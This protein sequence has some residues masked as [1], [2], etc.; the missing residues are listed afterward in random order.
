M[1][2]GQVNI[3]TAN[4]SN[5]R[6][7]SNLLEYQLSA[8]TVNSTNF[9]KLASLPVDGQVYA[10]PLYVS[11]L[12]F[13]GV[14]RNVL[15]VATMHN[16]IFAFDA[17]STE[18]LWQ[19]TL[20]PSVPSAMLFG[21][22]GDIGG[23]V[24]I[25]S[26]PVIDLQRSIIYAVT[27]N[28]RGGLPSFS[29]HAL[30]LATGSEQL[31][32]PTIIQAAVPGSGAGGSAD[33]NVHLDPQQHIQRPGLLLANGTVY[34][35][36][37]SHGDQPPYHGW[38][39]SYDAG[40]LT[41][42]L[43]IYMST[44]NGEGGAFWQSG[45]GPAVD[46][47]GNIYAAS[48]NG[49][50]DNVQNF[51]QSFLKLSGASP[52]L[53]GSFTPSGWKAMSDADAD[54]AAGPALIS[55]THRVIGADKDGNF[56]YLDGDAMSQPGS[57]DGN[58]FQVF[59]ISAGSI[60]NF[61]VW[62]RGTVASIYVQGQGE[63]LKCFQITPTGFNAL[64]LSTTSTSVQY[65]RIGM[66]LS[67]NGAADGSGI[68]WEIT[69]NYNDTT[70]SGT[71]HAYDASNLSSELWNSEMNPADKMG[72]L[73]KF[74][75]PT[76]ANGKVYVPTLSNGVVI[77]GML[78]SAPDPQATAPFISAVASSAS[79]ATD[80]VSPGQLVAIFGSSLGPST[81]SSLQLDASGNVTNS[82]GGTQVLF[83]GTPAALIWTSANQVNA[84]VPFGISAQ[85]TQIQVQYQGQASDS[86]AVAVAPS[87][88]GI[89]SLDGSG[90]G[91][92]AIL[93]QDGSINS[94]AQ[95][96]AA[97]SSV[98]LF[99]TGAGQLSPAGVDGSVV[100]AS[101]LPVPTLPV[102]VQIGGV[103]ASVLYSGGAPG[104]VEG[105]LQVNVV[106][107]AGIASGPAVP[108]VLRVGSR[109]SQQGITISVQ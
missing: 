95:P 76:V 18:L 10:Q 94:A 86:V 100:T 91:P 48:G 77:Y 6:T 29:I 61:A 73:V 50:Y 72:P 8:S 70:T 20:G 67:A 104:L 32:G 42:Q 102:S 34:V 35:G 22:Y 37:G 13:G 66:T 27:D 30:D 68:L 16:S 19:T 82:I 62:S 1:L 9:G 7:N 56:Y 11:S 45:R 26:T 41:H 15:F 79:Y 49:D 63:P 88:P 40:D 78:P 64:P 107:P 38:L 75:G 53:I 71:L 89:F 84:V 25:L 69:G 59:T 97:G 44:P 28:L 90:A 54:L 87:T 36:F 23:E 55:G 39:V 80:A 31:G 3:L 92:G 47:Q 4:G 101:N 65:E 52:S 74:V 12:L 103:D 83:D 105:V 33:G 81:P 108:V 109:S 106:V 60:F 51:G 21:Q 98:T 46:D 58:A 43:G 5:D 17:D 93:N 99:A 2:Q 85:T 14:S 96:A 24:G 57:A